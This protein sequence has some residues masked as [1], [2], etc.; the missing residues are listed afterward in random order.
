[1]SE[2]SLAPVKKMIGILELILLTSATA[3]DPDIPV[4]K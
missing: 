1:M 3:S 4:S 2:S